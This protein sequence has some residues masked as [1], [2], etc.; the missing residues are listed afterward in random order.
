MS[1]RPK[2][3]IFCIILACVTLATTPRAGASTSLVRIPLKG[4]A[5]LQSLHE[6]GIDVLALNRDGTI[7][8]A[9][10]ERQVEYLFGL[11]LPASVIATPEMLS[12][13]STALDANLGLYHTLAE[14]DSVMGALVAAYPSLASRQ[15]IG[16]SLEGRDIHVLKVSDNVVV[17]ESEPEVIYMGNHHARELMA[18]EIPLRFAVYLLDNYGTDAAVTNM[19][20]TREIY[21]IPMVNPDGHVYVEQNHAGSWT[22]WWRK[23]R[24]DNGDGTIG[25]DINRNYG[26]QWGYDNLGSSPSTSSPVYRGGSAFSEPE[27][28]AIRDFCTARNFSVGF[29]YHSYGELLLYGWGYIFDYTPDHNVFL[30]MGD[31][32]VSS[33]GYFAGNPA[34]GAIYLTNG[35][36]DDWAYGENVTKN[37]FFS[38]TPEVNTGAQGGFGPADTLIQPTFD[39]VLPMNMLLLELADNPYRVL[40]PRPP[41][42]LVVDNTFDPNLILSWGG[43]DPTDPNPVVSYE[44]V[45]YKEL[46]FT[47]QDPANATSPLW[48]YGGFSHSTARAFEGTGSYYSGAVD[49]RASTLSA[50]TF[51]RV[52]AESDTFTAM[53]WYNIETHWDY[54][55]LE[56]STDGGIVWSSV[57]GNRTTNFDPNGNNRGNGITGASGG[58]VL[59]LFPLTGYLGMDIHIRINYIT[60][61]FFLE[62]GMY[63]DLPGP[64][65]TY[66]AKAIVASNITGTSI[67][68]T[69]SSTGDFT[70]QVRARDAENHASVWSNSQTT[71]VTN[72]STGIGEV[73]AVASHLGPN[74]PNPF[75]PLTR[76]PYT[77]AAP[78]RSRVPV[79]LAIYD[80]SGSRVAT[81][82]RRD[83]TPGLYQEVW[84][85]VDDRG[86]ALP[87]GVYFARLTVAGKAVSVRKV[88]LL[89]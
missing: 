3:I 88:V 17:D 65:P 89:K 76:L 12:A 25:V 20:D 85:G 54:A 41:A 74:F 80:V 34:M 35:D 27:T 9:A 62:E 82:V 61:A 15:M 11:G 56:V 70:Y 49:N 2:I 21:F 33:N 64:V 79:T 66:T 50:A 71:T 23:N 57:P 67:V 73:P 22:T 18:V 28:Q 59:A 36:T 38:F 45:E 87:S 86:D 6:R 31:S 83:M 16:Q 48:K 47:P 78:G 72:T 69:P 40:G 52:A 7:D 10:D 58:W 60:D 32:L 46:G 30:A 44:V 51:Y 84:K 68:H 1:Y 42:A 19:V 81:L 5:M 77:V 43:N 39:Q 63:V 75:N 29:S 8:V 4:S 53:V 26:Y 24:R 55:Y 13:A 14:M 37:S